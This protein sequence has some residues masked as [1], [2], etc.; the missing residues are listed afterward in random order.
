LHGPLNYT[1]S[2]LIVYFQ[3]EFVDTRT[4]QEREEEK[5]RKEK[6]REEAR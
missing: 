1:Y 2:S 3:L 6:G 4:K 5:K